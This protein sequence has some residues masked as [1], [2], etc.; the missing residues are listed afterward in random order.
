MEVETIK[1]TQRETN[2]EIETLGKKSGL[3]DVSVSKRIQR[4]KRESLVQKIS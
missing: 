1:I 2:M 3:I 4:W